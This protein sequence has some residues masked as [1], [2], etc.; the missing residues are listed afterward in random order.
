MASQIQHSLPDYVKSDNEEGLSFLRLG[1]AEM[2]F[3]LSEIDKNDIAILEEKYDAEE[4]CAGIAAPQIGI[5]KKVIIFAA[6]DR[7]DLK[8]WRPDLSQTMPKTIWINPSYQPIGEEKYK[9]YE[10][11]FSVPDT[12]APIW[13]YKKIHYKAYDIEGNLVEGEAEGFLARIIQH[14]I[15]HIDGTLFIDYAEQDEIFSISEYKEK[16]KASMEAGVD[17]QHQDDL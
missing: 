9:D 5:Q 16:R 15:D 3:P 6:E 10:A 14:E 2:H 8:K 12:A 11:C 4:N 17:R 13:R 1:G 7:E